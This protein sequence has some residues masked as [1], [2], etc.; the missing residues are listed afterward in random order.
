MTQSSDCSVQSAVPSRRHASRSG[1][2]RGPDTG[3][4][5]STRFDFCEDQL[6]QTLKDRK[7]SS[8][9]TTQAR[10]LLK[11]DTGPEGPE[12]SDTSIAEAFE[13][14]TQTVER[15]RKRAVTEGVDVALQ[16]RRHG[17]VPPKL[18]GEQEARLTALRCSEPP[19]GQTRWTLHLL[20]NRF[21]DREG[22]PVSFELVRRTLKRTGCPLT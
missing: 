13:V 2:I 17:T 15:L 19:A 8:R 1:K 5:L 22:V 14:S 11:A 10:I 16:E 21:S 4:T 3:F 20:A 12:W 6:Q 9:Q 7:A 18:S